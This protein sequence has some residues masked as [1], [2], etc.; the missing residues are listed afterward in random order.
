MFFLNS[1][2]V[3]A[4]TNVLLFLLITGLAC[5]VDFQDFRHRFKKPKGLVTGILCQF[6][7]VPLCAYVSIIVFAVDSVVGIPLLAIASS[8][9]KNF[10]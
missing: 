1:F 7:I 5:T 9:G 2:L 10:E 8:P 4:V 3:K 6:F